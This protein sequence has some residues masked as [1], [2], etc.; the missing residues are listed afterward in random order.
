MADQKAVPHYL[1]DLCD[2]TETLTLAE[3]QLQAQSLIEQDAPVET[4]SQM[5]VDTA[6]DQRVLARTHGVPFPLLV[7]GTG[8]YLRAITRGL[9]I[10]RVPP[11]PELRSQL[12]SLG[13]AQCYAMLQQIDPVA[14][15]KIHGHDQVR[16]VRSLEVFYTTGRPMSQQQGE[17][18]PSYP[19][20]HLG[21][22][23]QEPT[24]LHRRIQHRTHQMVIEGL[25]DE[26]EYLSRK[27][28]RD[29][30]LL[31]TLGYAEFKQALA[32]E[33]SLTGAEEMTVLHTRQF[34]KRQRTWF[35]ACPEIEW[36]DADAPDLEDLV[37]QRVQRFVDDVITA[38]KD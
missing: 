13:Q 31:N 12:Q 18:P 26:V 4:G 21:L 20:L 38:G 19:I 2:P 3:Y 28:G 22:D 23:C 9:R 32:G 1:I 15:S 10:P 14:A 30:P 37:W 8:L 27:Y 35:R 17:S 5:F 16:T 6:P 25:A 7:G 36:F 34:A 29:L 33:I 11:Q 24:H